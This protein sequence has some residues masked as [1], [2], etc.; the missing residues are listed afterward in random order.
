VGDH[1]TLKCPYRDVMASVRGESGATGEGTPLGG[2]DDGEGGRLGSGGPGHYVP[3][4]ARGGGGGGGGAAGGGAAGAAADAASMM[5]AEELRRLRIG[6]LA[7]DV[8]E[9]DIRELVAP[10][11]HVE[12]VSLSRHRDSNK[13]TAAYVT[14]MHHDEAERARKD[15]DG[16][17]FRYLLLKVE[18]AKPNLNK[19]FLSGSQGLSG[20]F[21]SGY[22]KALPQKFD[23]K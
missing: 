11:G 21:V 5:P 18:W 23:R 10:Y 16:V 22:G 14:F 15:L 4:A 3:P 1:Y 17:G 12:R 20:G 13:V 19:D 6:N 7:E 9:D 2:M 8:E